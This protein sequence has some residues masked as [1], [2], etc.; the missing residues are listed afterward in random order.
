MRKMLPIGLGSL[1]LAALAVAYLAR[2]DDARAQAGPP[3]LVRYGD[4]IV[5]LSR[6]IAV[7]HQKDEFVRFTLDSERPDGAVMEI[8]LSKEMSPEP[9]YVEQ[10]WLKVVKD[11]RVGN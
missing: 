5:D 6:V 4:V 1:I 8:T 11:L 2:P 10:H 9:G 7:T 3:E